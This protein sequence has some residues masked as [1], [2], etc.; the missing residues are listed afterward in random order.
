MALVDGTVGAELTK[1]RDGRG[2]KPFLMFGDDVYSYADVEERSARAAN[3]LRDIGVSKDDH[4]ALILPNAPE[5]LWAWFGAAR[6]GAPGV[7]V[8]TAL[9][10]DG[11]VHI[12]DHSDS[13]TLIVHADLLDRVDPV[14]SRLP[15]LKRVVVVGGE[16]GDDVA[17]DRLIQASPEGADDESIGASDLMLIMYTSGTT[18]LP[19]GVVIP[20]AQIVGVPFLAAMAGLTSDD[21][22]YTCLPLFHANAALISIWG[23]FGLGTKVGLSPRFSASRFWD[24]V[25]RYGATEFNAL[26][27]MM[28]ILHKQPPKPDDADNPCRL[29]VSAACPKEIWEDFERRF[30]VEI[31]EFY[32]T[33][34]GGLTMAGSDAPPGSI[35]K[36]LAI[37]EMRVVRDDDTDCD[38]MEV[39]EIISRPAGGPP[40]VQYYKNPEATAEKVAGGW[41]RSGDLA[42][43][44]EDGYYWFVDRKKDSMR[45]RGENI[46]SF[47]VERALNEHPDVLESAVYA[48]PSELGEDEVMAALV[49]RPGAKFDPI[50]IMEHADGTMAYFMVPRYLR[51]VTELDKTGTHRVQKAGLRAEGI[52]P[53]T[54]DREAAGFQ[55]TR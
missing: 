31:V 4:V 50:S 43:V 26:G 39:G 42:Y 49:L 30:G 35:G 38:A 15:K 22:F 46:S 45:R 34:E 25:R 18:G 33:V 55:V 24:E 53:E 5:F 10:G 48:V 21:V 37:N 51:V 13:E 40:T 36:P 8:N 2:D 32:G 17:W 19:K 52:T 28:P 20:Q 9:K 29:V 11:L 54:W 41:M 16:A 3:G 6:I 44:D 27:A 12:V 1:A 23:A 47:E 7:P 14:R